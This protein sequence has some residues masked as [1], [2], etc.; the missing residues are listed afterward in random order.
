MA[1]KGNKEIVSMSFSP[2]VLQYIDNYVS[3]FEKKTGNKMSRSAAIGGII[4][5]LAENDSGIN[6]INYKWFQGE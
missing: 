5:L 2:E 6:M 1:T 4:L 3:F